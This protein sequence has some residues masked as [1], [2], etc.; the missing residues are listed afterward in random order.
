VSQ[1]YRAKCARVG[2]DIAAYALGV[3]GT[4]EN[5]KV[6]QVSRFFD[7]L[8][9]EVRLGAWYWLAPGSP[10]WDDPVLWSR[11]LETPYEESRL[12]LMEALQRRA[13]L[14]GV[15]PGDLAPLWSSVLLGVHR[16][17]RHKLIALRQISDAVRADSENAGKLLPVLTVAIRSVRLPEARAGLAALAAAVEVQPELRDPLRKQL[18]E[19]ELTEEVVPA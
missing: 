3:I 2:K 18:G 1:L 9:A 4:R 6:D 16:G 11:L 15:G 12:R 19:L 8:L 14:P 7:S 17:G 10:G 5:Y 13:K